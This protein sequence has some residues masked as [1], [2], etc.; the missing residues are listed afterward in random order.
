MT[1][2]DTDGMG[3][4]FSTTE[5][6]EYT[7]V[8]DASS[9]VK[10]LRVASRRPWSDPIA[11]SWYDHFHG[12]D[13][14]PAPDWS[15]R[16]DHR[17]AARPPADRQHPGHV[18]REAPHRRAP[19]HGQACRA[20]LPAGRDEPRRDRLGVSLAHPLGRSRR[21]GLLL[22]PPGRDRR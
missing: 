7:E 14:H 6:A 8:D 18:R 11:A 2:M 4:E 19:H 13:P 5:Y 9:V 16:P 20:R 22:R 10:P 1:P 12:T 3:E 17:G 21:P 15:R